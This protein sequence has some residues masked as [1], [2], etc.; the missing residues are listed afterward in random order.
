[1]C[2]AR[3]AAQV[4]VTVA[5]SMTLYD[6]DSPSP[7]CLRMFLLEKGLSVPSLTIDVFGGEN[8]RAP[9]LGLN[10]AGQTPALALGDGAVLAESVAIAEYLEE[11]CPHPA[12]IGATALE[13]ALTRQWWRRVELNVTEFIHNAY[14]YA[15]GLDRFRERIPV[16]PEA[17]A[18]LKRV[19]Q[20]RLAWLDA[21]LEE[22]P[23]L[24]G[25]R[26]SAADIWLY[27]W[28]DFGIAVG[29][30]FDRGLKRLTPW[31]DRIAARPSAA[32]SRPPLRE[33]SPDSVCSPSPSEAS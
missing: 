3:G 19:A 2:L 13:R 15:E 32:A 21:L 16:A 18:G 12:L 5:A 22:E 30:P 11:C 8:R 33:R 10:P 14:H 25:Q 31:F 27:V 9:F 26:I 23:F 4:N 1:M 7:R 24:C 6:A 20:D 17:A 29:Q 28:L